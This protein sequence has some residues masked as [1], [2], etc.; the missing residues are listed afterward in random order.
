VQG[1]PVGLEDVLQVARLALVRAVH[2]DHE[3]ACVG[4]PPEGGKERVRLHGKSFGRP[5][6]GQ[7]M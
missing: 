6:R 5:R 4:T 2:L 1:V 3:H 7:S